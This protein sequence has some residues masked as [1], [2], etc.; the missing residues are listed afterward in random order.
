MII[1]STEIIEGHKVYVYDDIFSSEYIN[2]EYEK[3]LSTKFARTEYASY[4]TEGSKHWISEI[5]TDECLSSVFWN[6]AGKILQDNIRNK[7]YRPYRAYTNYSSYGDVLYTHT[8]CVPGKNEYTLLC[9][10]CNEWDVEWGGETVF[11]NSKLD[12]KFIVTP[13]PGR[14]IIFDSAVRHV[15]K[16]PNRNC[17]NSRFTSVIKTEMY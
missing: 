7:K 16:P 17:Y 12:A 14:L 3:L 4:E 8:D 13:K 1:E 2:S 10:I 9:Y 6:V 5:S 11:F 15:G